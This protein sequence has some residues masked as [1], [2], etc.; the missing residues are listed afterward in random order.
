MKE[1]K[2]RV[3]CDLSVME[4]Y[5]VLKE[6]FSKG[7][8]LLINDQEAI[9]YVAENGYTELVRKLIEAGADVTADNNN[10]IKWASYNGHAE[11][12]RLLIEAGADVTANNN[13]AIIYAS[14]QGHV[15]VVKLLIEAGA[16]VTAQN[17][18]AIMRASEEGH[19]EVVRLLIEAGADVT[20]D[21]NYAIKCASQEGYV[22]I[23]R[24]LIEAGADVTA[25]DIKEA[26][27]KGYTEILELL[28][29]AYKLQKKRIEAIAKVERD[30]QN[31][32]F[33]KM[34]Y[35]YNI[36]QEEPSTVY[37]IKDQKL[38]DDLANLSHTVLTRD[39]FDIE[40]QKEIIMYD[41]KR[42][43]CYYGS[44]A[45]YERKNRIIVG[46]TSRACFIEINYMLDRISQTLKENNGGEILVQY[47]DEVMTVEEF[48]QFQENLRIYN[49]V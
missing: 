37:G 35:G 33:V 8:N 14:S 21:D 19:V 5:D 20:A 40:R 31:C 26:S 7:T 18:Y 1:R 44:Q 29:E 46:T 49:T 39:V 48:Y 34:L 22:E 32:F 47:K 9:C 15:E 6:L 11:V 30:A 43:Q 41:L 45:N 27:R 3:T 36:S 12:V 42:E 2:A 24:L 23:V 16:D 38:L 25:D 4:Q 10:A 17:S 13:C 28:Q